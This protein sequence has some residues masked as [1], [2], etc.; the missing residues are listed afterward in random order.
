MLTLS[1]ELLSSSQTKG[2]L[3]LHWKGNTN[4]RS[5][6]LVG[7]W[8]KKA[9]YFLSCV[10]EALCWE[11][12]SLP[13]PACF[14][15]ATNTVEKP[16]SRCY[17]LMSPLGQRHHKVDWVLLIYWGSTLSEGNQWAA[18][19]NPM[20][21]AQ[22]PKPHGDTTVHPFQDGGISVFKGPGHAAFI[23]VL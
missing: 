12:S 11:R 19:Q 22:L 14:D 16:H 18:K 21:G 3:S 23:C 7:M 13:N 10:Q 1:N 20:D 9:H 15:P 8:L 6:N 5:W 2:S 4:E 17:F